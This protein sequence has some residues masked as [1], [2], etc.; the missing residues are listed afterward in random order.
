MPG[1]GAGNDDEGDEG[2][3]LWLPG[4]C[5]VS[6]KMVPDPDMSAWDGSSSSGGGG[7]PS[8]SNG[9]GA[10]ALAA[11][12]GASA[13]PRG[14]VMSFSWLLSEGTCLGVERE[15]TYEGRLRE[16]RNTSA[17]RGG[18]SGGRVLIQPPRR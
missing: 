6:F 11:G 1:L 16:V 15:Y 8:S 12:G 4:G 17:V 7:G 10:R 9:N 13:P 14:V 5:I 18:W 2:G 3:S